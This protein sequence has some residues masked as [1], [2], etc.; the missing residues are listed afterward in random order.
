MKCSLESQAR[1]RLSVKRKRMGLLNKCLVNYDKKSRLPQKVEALR[2]WITS[3][4][5]LEC[6]FAYYWTFWIQMTSRIFLIKSFAQLQLSMHIKYDSPDL[7]IWSE[8]DRTYQFLKLYLYEDLT[9]YFSVQ[10][11]GEGYT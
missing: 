10:Y 4:K 9:L 8:L 7:T 2:N 3:V 1:Y 6:T 11:L 5:K